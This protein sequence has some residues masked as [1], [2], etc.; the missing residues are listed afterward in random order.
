M[1]GAYALHQMRRL[2]KVGE[3]S[4]QYQHILSLVCHKTAQSENGVP[5]SLRHSDVIKRLYQSYVASGGG[6]R[7]WMLLLSL[8]EDSAA[9]LCL[10]RSPEALSLAS[11]CSSR[12]WY[13]AR[14]S[15]TAPAAH[16][17]GRPHTELSQGVRFPVITFFCL[18][19]FHPW[20]PP[21]DSQPISVESRRERKSKLSVESQS[22]LC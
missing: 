1:A 17:T 13:S 6:G 8:P 21:H 16:H 10:R 9:V 7:T 22:N 18:C 19:H 3:W 11:Y 14:Q 4:G 5:V 2:S 20:G 15:T 12:H